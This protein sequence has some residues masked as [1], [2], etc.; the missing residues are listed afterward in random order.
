MSVTLRRISSLVVMSA[1]SITLIA[2]CSKKDDAI[3][4]AAKTDASKGVPAPSIEQTKAI[5]EEGFV[6]GLP[7]VMNYA[8]MY[9]FAVDSTSSQFKAPF[10]QINNQHRVATYLDSAVITPNSDTPYSMLWLDL[11]AEP[12]VIT[13]PAVPKPRYYSVQLI[14]GNTYNYGYIGSRTT[15]TEAGSYLVAG[16]GW[17]GK[18]PAGIKKVV[19]VDDAL[20]AHALPHA[21]VRPGRHAER[22]EG[23][24]RLSR[25]PLSAFL[26]QPAPPAAPKID[27][28]RRPRPGSKRISTSTSP[29]RCSSFR[30]PR[31]TA[32]SARGSRASA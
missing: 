23:A 18:A 22:R 14:D 10:N 29:S 7:L 1:T 12:I 20:H 13:V 17:T 6:Y 8:V 3:S 30:P 2:G 25:A 16:P 9:E 32:G 4:Q 21:A 11:R 31:R 24:V 19:H 27:F 26:K 15:G 28:L 5:A